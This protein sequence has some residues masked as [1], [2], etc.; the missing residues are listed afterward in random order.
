MND[1]KALVPMSDI[2]EMAKAA[3]S[4]G[5]F[6]SLKSPDAIMTLMLLCQAEGLH[7]I[8]ALRRY[9]IV[10]GRPGL[11]ADAMLGEF[12]NRGGIVT[13]HKNTKE[14]CSATFTAP[15]LGE[16]V[17]VTWTIADAKEAGLAGKPG[18]WQQYPR[19]MLRA[20]VTSEGVRMAMPGIVVGLYTPEEVG[21]FAQVL[22]PPAKPKESDVEKRE[23]VVVTDI[24]RVFP[25]AKQVKPWLT[26]LMASL[27]QLDLGRKKAD[28]LSLRGKAREEHLRTAR[29]LYLSW[30]TGRTIESSKD[31]TDEEAE[32]AIRRADN[33]EMP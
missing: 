2:R 7:P 1:E 12:Q 16:P 10:Q 20:R 21:D 31:L 33:G 32:E 15:G 17:T 4:S 3:A 28:E 8:Q 27:N 19:Q 14:E 29:L 26:R 30:V 24:Q 23:T 18:P 5:L 6:P 13:W 9:D 22:I 25:E 11:K